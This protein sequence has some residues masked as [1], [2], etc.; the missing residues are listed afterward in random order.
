VLDVD[1]VDDT[2]TRPLRI[3]GGY[4]VSYMNN[5]VK[6]RSEANLEYMLSLVETIKTQPLHPLS[7]QEYVTVTTPQKKDDWAHS[8]KNWMHVLWQVIRF[9]IVGGL[10]TAIDILLL[11]VFLWIYPT[12][13]TSLVLLFNSIAYVIGAVNSFLLNKYWTFKNYKRP[14][15]SEIARF[16]LTTA[17][18]VACSDVILWGANVLLTRWISDTTLLTNLSKLLAILGTVGISYVGMHLWVFVQ[19]TKD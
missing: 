7:Q 12:N 2:D 10:N 8:N 15:L 3:P 17:I 11:N 19:K 6:T 9:G 4:V 1:E 16:A 14:T 5:A 13:V 18:G